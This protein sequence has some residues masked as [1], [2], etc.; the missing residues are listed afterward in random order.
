MF[1]SL[2]QKLMPMRWNCEEDEQL[3][4]EVKQM[5]NILAAFYNIFPN[6]V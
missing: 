2:S 4:K 5:Y 3:F 1:Q 6:Q